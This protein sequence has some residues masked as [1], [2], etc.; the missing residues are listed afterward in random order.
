MAGPPAGVAAVRRAVRGALAT[1][2]EGL[3]LVACSGGA[4]SLALASAAAFEADKVGRPVGAVVVDHGLQQGSAQVAERAADQCR[5]LGLSPV[6]VRRVVVIEHGQG[7]E[8]AAR[9]A[10]YAALDAARDEVG[11]VA[12]LLAH[13]RDDQAE[14][15]LLGLARGSGARSLAAM[16]PANGP[17]VRPLLGIGREATEQCCAHDGL[18]PWHDPHNADPTYARVRA[19]HAIAMLETDLG[20]GLA[21]SLA[22]SAALLRAD[23]EALD[24][25]ACEARARFEHPASPRVD[26]LTP[27]MAAVRTR[28]LRAIA[29]DAGAPPGALTQTHVHELDRLVTDW[30]GQGPVHLPG[31]LL[32]TRERVGGPSAPARIVVAPRHRQQ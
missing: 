20:P 14:Q 3:V 9:E 18:T 29:V 32:A 17:W 11:A 26:E 10:R 31:P 1:L 6:L 16:A 8:A 30:H 2:P 5:G 22:R 15:V 27:L 4:D 12:V 21:A 7:P 19:R 25:L 28:V 23:A 13:T 24:S